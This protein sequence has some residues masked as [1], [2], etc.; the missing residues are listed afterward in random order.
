MSMARRDRRV[1]TPATS[2]LGNHFISPHPSTFNV[3]LSILPRWHS[4]TQPPLSPSLPPTPSTLH[5]TPQRTVRRVVRVPPTRRR[6][7][8]VIRPSL[9]LC[10]LSINAVS[11]PRQLDNTALPIKHAFVLAFPLERRSSF[12]LANARRTPVNV[13]TFWSHNPPNKFAFRFN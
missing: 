1:F 4:P 7:R 10:G 9:K 6:V 3:Y 2:F 11:S 5:P 12:F 8:T 13:W